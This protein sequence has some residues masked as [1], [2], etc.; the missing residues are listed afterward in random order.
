MR[1]D[2]FLKA[3]GITI[4]EFGRRLGLNKQTMSRYVRGHRLPP[5]DLLVR[6]KVETDG[7]VTADDF[8][9]H[10]AELR[11]VTT[12]VATEAPA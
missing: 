9:G 7:E 8:A 1:L 5:A 12:P 3:Q 6:I 11:N 2:A 10:V 4:T